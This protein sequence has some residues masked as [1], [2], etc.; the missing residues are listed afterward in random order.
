MIRRN[1]NKLKDM[2]FIKVIT[3][4]DEVLLVSNYKII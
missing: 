1:L 4:K 2:V 3:Y